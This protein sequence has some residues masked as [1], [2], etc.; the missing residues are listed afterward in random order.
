MSVGADSGIVLLRNE[1]VFDKLISFHKSK[2]MK[3]KKMMD[4]LIL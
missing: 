1:V 2:K 3:S 4:K